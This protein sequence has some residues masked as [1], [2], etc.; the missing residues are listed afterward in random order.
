M[1]KEMETAIAN[2]DCEKIK[3][4]LESKP[5]FGKG[6][7]GKRKEELKEKE[8]TAEVC[9]EFIEHHNERQANKAKMD[10]AIEAEDYDKLKELVEE[11]GFGPGKSFGRKRMKEREANS[12]NEAREISQEFL[13]KIVEKHKSQEAIKAEMDAAIEAEDYD[14]L[15]E[16]VEKNGF[17]PGKPFGRK[18][19]MRR[20]GKGHRGGGDHPCP[21]RDK[22][23]PE[24]LD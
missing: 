8:F 9:Q 6:R 5:K 23:S 4:I 13:E 7:R 12:E 2:Q 18:G 1:K 17:G 24:N 22:V 16:L 19:G 21:C 10:A 20:H 15:K 14:K 11:K 3:E